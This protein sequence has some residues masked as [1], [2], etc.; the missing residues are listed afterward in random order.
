MKNEI[1]GSLVNL[2]SFIWWLKPWF[3]HIFGG[4]GKKGKGYDSFLLKVQ[5]GSLEKV[6][7][8]LIPNKVF[9]GFV[10]GLKWIEPTKDLSYLSP[11]RA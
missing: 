2:K 3:L 6:M 10:I 5:E 1:V 9:I 7:K 8:T 4:N 11:L